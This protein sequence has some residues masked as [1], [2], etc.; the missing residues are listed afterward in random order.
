[1]RGSLVALLSC[2]V[3]WAAAVSFAAESRDE[4]SGAKDSETE[5]VFNGKDLSDWKWVS[6]KEGSSIHDVWSVENGILKCKG[7][8]RGY[9]RTK[10]DDYRNYVLVVEWR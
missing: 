5:Q 2:T 10:R 7:N 3:V 1:M 8:P 9:I 4:G 6:D